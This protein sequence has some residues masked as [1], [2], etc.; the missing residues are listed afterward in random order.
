MVFELWSDFFD[1]HGLKISV[2]RYDGVWIAHGDSGHFP[3]LSGRFDFFRFYF[4][5]V[6]QNRDFFR[7][8]FWFSHVDTDLYGFS[9]FDRQI[10]IFDP[11]FRLYGNLCFVCQTVIVHVFSNTADPVSAH[12][13]FGTVRVVHCHPEIRLVR[14]ADQDQTVGTDAEMTVTD[15][16]R[17]F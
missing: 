16:F 13:S 6:C 9:V 12:G 1:F 11:A 15:D 2:I 3:G 4:F 10:Q 7:T 17:R 14:R 5:L 8:A